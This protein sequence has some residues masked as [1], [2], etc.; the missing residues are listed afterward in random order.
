MSFGA[1]GTF[2]RTNGINSTGKRV[3]Q[4]DAAAGI[5]ILDTRHDTH[6]Q[7]LA[8]GLS[9]CLLRN[10][11][12]VP[13]ANIPWG[14]FKITNLGNPTNPQDVATKYYVDNPAAAVT[15]RDING[16]D[17]NGRL[18]FTAPSGV[19][20][21]TWTYA[22]LAWVARHS[23]TGEGND[24]LVMTS[25]NAPS[26]ADVAAGLGDVFVI[27]DA[28]RINNAAGR[29]TNN[30]SYDAVQAR[31]ISPGTGTILRYDTG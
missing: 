24:R 18:N 7:D 16:A 28:G 31:T 26:T 27:D 12:G 17:L 20:G 13:T 25:T 8:E 14:G 6:D 11:A 19:N 4:D 29:L 1:D 22:N 30:V 15:A 2:T 23:K 3:W 9:Q 10:G 5:K 21:I